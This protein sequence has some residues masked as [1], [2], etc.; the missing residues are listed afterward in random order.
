MNLKSA[1]LAGSR[2][3]RGHPLESDE[4]ILGR[5][6]EGDQEAFERLVKRYEARVRNLAF[7]FVRDRALAED[8]AQDAFLRAYQKAGSIKRGESVRSWLYRVAINRAQDE[9]RRIKRKR[10]VALEDGWA[11]LDSGRHVSGEAL[12]E[13]MELGR[14]LTRALALLRSEHRIPLVMRE[15][16]GMTY[17]EIA[18][19][20]GWPLGTVQVR[21]HRGRLEL[22][23]ILGKLRGTER[24]R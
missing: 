24:R 22:R 18:E 21:I 13:S 9:I 6:L 8:I 4:Q 7:G 14:H 16:Q 5:F 23:E 19:L 12:V 11:H 2:F 20:L 15:V 3:A 10:E 17:A 1:L